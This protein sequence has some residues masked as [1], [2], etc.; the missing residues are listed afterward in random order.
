M[1]R[2]HD[3]CRKKS[4]PIS[5]HRVF[6]EGKRWNDWH[7]IPWQQYMD[8][9]LKW[10]M[11]SL[12]CQDVSCAPCAH[13]MCCDM[14]LI[15]VQSG[16]TKTRKPDMIS[17]AQQQRLYSPS[18]KTS[19]RRSRDVPK[20]RDS[21][22]DFSN[23]FEIWQAPRQQRYRDACHIPKRYNHY[24][25]Q[26]RDFTRFGSMTSYRLVNKGPEVS[27][28]CADGPVSVGPTK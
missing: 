22:F 8:I 10:T 4:L 24:N 11:T 17:C 19:Y 28:V 14:F 27:T 2:N 7:G 9:H 6:N 25:I 15:D 1:K 12:T 26:S 23:R 5:W 18:G 3:H 20:P 13:Y 16:M 21:G